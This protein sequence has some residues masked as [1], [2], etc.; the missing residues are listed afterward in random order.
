MCLLDATFP[1]IQA[2]D[3]ENLAYTGACGSRG[4]KMG[5]R[6]PKDRE[7]TMF[8]DGERKG[9][10]EGTEVDSKTSH[11]LLGIRDGDDTH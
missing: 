3:Q 10:Q 4:E 9:E 6:D 7:L 8:C 5:L 1:L 2:K 11:G